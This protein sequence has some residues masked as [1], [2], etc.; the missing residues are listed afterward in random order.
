MGL[1]HL[2]W[3][4]KIL[5]EHWNGALLQICEEEFKSVSR[6]WLKW[7]PIT[8]WKS[9]RLCGPVASHTVALPAVAVKS[10]IP[11][12]EPC[13]GLS[14]VSFWPCHASAYLASFTWTLACWAEQAAVFSDIPPA[15][16]KKNSYSWPSNSDFALIVARSWIQGDS[17][18]AFQSRIQQHPSRSVLTFTV[19]CFGHDYIYPVQ[20]IPFLPRALYS[21]HICTR[22]DSFHRIWDRS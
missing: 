17:A 1:L 7:D 18:P 14:E 12:G 15:L 9:P 10:S 21:S 13:K 4:P 3:E 16:T 2:L 11:R 20:F 22:T 8:L 6:T 5:S 19:W